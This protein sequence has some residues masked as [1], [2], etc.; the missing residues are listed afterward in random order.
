M[1]TSGGE[2]TDR[3]VPRTSRP[4]RGFRTAR[5]FSPDSAQ[6]D[7]AQVVQRVVDHLGDTPQDPD[8]H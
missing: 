3:S 1:M 7:L 2:G 5:A 8:S 4:R 6:P